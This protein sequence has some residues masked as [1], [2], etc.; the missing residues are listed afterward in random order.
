VTESRFLELVRP[1]KWS[2]NVFPAAFRPTRVVCDSVLALNLT[3]DTNEDLSTETW[4]ISD[5]IGV[6]EHPQ[7]SDQPNLQSHQSSPGPSR[8][9]NLMF[10]LMRVVKWY[11]GADEEG[12]NQEMPS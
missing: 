1:V 6:F 2:S 9:L 3:T 11:K 7:P 12:H 8:D 5:P 10:R 4:N